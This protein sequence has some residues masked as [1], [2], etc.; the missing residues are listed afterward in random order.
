MNAEVGKPRGLFF[1]IL[2]AVYQN[3]TQYPICAERMATGEAF[4]LCGVFFFQFSAEL[5]GRSEKHAGESKVQ[6]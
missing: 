3:E 1:P 4:L 2:A 6:A 5:V